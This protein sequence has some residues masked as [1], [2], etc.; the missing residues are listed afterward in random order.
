MRTV[1]YQYPE[2]LSSTDTYTAAFRRIAAEH[3]R[4]VKH[5]GT[6]P[7]LTT[8]EQLIAQAEK[9]MGLE[10]HGELAPTEG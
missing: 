7:S 6:S 2:H 1:R 3:A 4:G 5:D 8:A 10:P 9:E